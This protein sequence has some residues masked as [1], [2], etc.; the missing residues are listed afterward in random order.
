MRLGHQAT[1]APLALGGAWGIAAS[2]AAPIGV[3]LAFAGLVVLSCTWPDLDHPRFKGRMHPGAALVRG[4]ALLAY[5]IRTAKDQDREDLHRGPSHCLEW[6]VAAGLLVA[7][8][9]ARV[10]SLA[11]WAWWFGAA[12]FAGTASHIAADL[13]TPSGVPVSA[14]WNW[15]RHGEV[16]KRHSWGLFTTDSAGERFLAVPLLFGVTGLMGLGM[17]GLLGPVVA[18][19]TGWGL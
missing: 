3:A 5:R 17:I 7:L 4:T 8:L 10:P 18:A 6:C 14:V 11:P 9:V 16:W 19:L 1:A 12:V 15:V 13:C 2:G